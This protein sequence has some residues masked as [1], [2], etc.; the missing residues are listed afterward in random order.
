MGACTE[1]DSGSI[2]GLGAGDAAHVGARPRRAAPGRPR[3][4]TAGRR[5]PGASAPRASPRAITLPWSTTTMSSAR[6]SASSR[7]WV[8]SRIVAPSSTSDSSTSHSSLRARGSRPGGG[9]VQEQ[10]LGPGDERRGQVQAAAHAA[11]VGLHQAPAGVGQAELL[12]QLVGAGARDAA[13]KVVQ[14][15]DHLEVLATGEQRVDGRVLRGEA[16]HLAHVARRRQHV[17]AGH[18]RRARVGDG[19]GGEDADGGGLPGAVGPEQA[20][21]GARAGPRSETPSSAVFSP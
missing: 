3:S 5:P 7:Y 10:H 17:D 2:A 20:A 19:E 16:Q 21:D 11:R 13:A 18:A 9:L 8:V 4:R 12:Q 14:L 1:R 15:A 6:R